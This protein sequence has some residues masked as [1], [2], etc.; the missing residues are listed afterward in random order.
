MKNHCG[1]QVMYYGTLDANIHK[2]ERNSYKGGLTM[3]LSYETLKKGY[4]LDVNSLYPFA[5]SG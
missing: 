2:I 4:Y 1:V 5:L 3:V